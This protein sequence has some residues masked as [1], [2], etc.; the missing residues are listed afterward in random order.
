MSAVDFSAE[1]RALDALTLLAE[2]AAPVR[3][4][5]EHVQ[6]APLAHEHDLLP[7]LV[8]VVASCGI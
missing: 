5:V 6:H 2:H 8:V 4:E 3:E 1:E 7:G